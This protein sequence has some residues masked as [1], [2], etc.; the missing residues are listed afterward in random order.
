[1]NTASIPVSPRRR[2]VL[3]VSGVML[4]FGLLGLVLAAAALLQAIDGTPIQLTIDGQTMAE[5]F[6]LADWSTGHWAWAV[7]GIAVAMLAVLVVV[8]L[9]LVV[10]A[11]GVLIGLVFGLG[12]PL[13]VVAL[14]AAVALSPL[15]LLG[16]LIWRAARPSPRVPA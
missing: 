15:A 16:W 7:L 10:A 11:I 1:M 5:P 13:L 2:W 14:L 9:A 4:L 8:P 12:L 6:T 3:R